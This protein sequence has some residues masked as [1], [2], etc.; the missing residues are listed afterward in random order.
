MRDRLF[1]N[2]VL[3][4]AG[5]ATVRDRLLASQQCDRLL[6]SQ[7]CTTSFVT[8]RDSPLASQQFVTIH[9]LR[10]NS[11]AQNHLLNRLIIEL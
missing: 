7:R 5:F 2:N 3:P 10:N 9:S 8:T 4:S 6:V 11:S 1:R